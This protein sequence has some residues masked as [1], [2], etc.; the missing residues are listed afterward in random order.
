[1]A[2][3]PIAD[4]AASSSLQ[5]CVLYSGRNPAYRRDRRTVTPSRSHAGKYRSYGSTPET[6]S[7]MVEQVEIHDLVPRGRECADELLFSV[8]ARVGL[9]ECT[10][11]GVG[12]ESKVDATGSPLDLAGAPVA[13]L[14]RRRLRVVRPRYPFGSRIEEVDEEVVRQRT[15]CRGEHTQRRLAVVGAEHT[16]AAE[17]HRH[18]ASTQSQLA[19]AVDEQ[20]F[21]RHPR[22]YVDVVA[23][24]VHGRL[25]RGEPFDVG[26]LLRC[27]RT[28]RPK[29]DLNVMTGPGGRLF[30][31]GAPTEHDQIGQRDLLPSRWESLKRCWIRW[32]V[33][34]AGTSV[35]GSLTAQ[36]RC[37]SRRMR[38]PL[39]PP[40]L[41]L[42][43]NVEADAHAVTTSCDTDR[44]ES[45][46]WLLRAPM[47]SASMSS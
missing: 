41:S 11:F 7:G 35:S 2:Q 42:L 43:R 8:L 27:V 1:M 33:P 37:G 5:H 25:E 21:R 4:R 39:A 9:R 46:S 31:R 38:A 34:S 20:V 30:D 16:Q 40:R 18:L 26:P 10:E 32:S 47:S 15:R 28:S 17:Q 22:P 3:R 36:L 19:R 6:G 45:R 13:A 44:P 29:R 14:I 24:C 12:P 23:E